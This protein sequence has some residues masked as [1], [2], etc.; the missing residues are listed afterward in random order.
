[1]IWISFFNKEIYL[2]NFTNKLGKIRKMEHFVATE[3]VAFR[4]CPVVGDAG[5]H[6]EL[7]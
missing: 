5:I 6:L 3:L 7:T 2:Q 1:M 4:L